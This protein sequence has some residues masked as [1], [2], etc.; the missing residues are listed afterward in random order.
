MKK[1]GGDNKTLP[2]KEMNNFRMITQMIELKKYKKAL[3]TCEQILKKYPKNGETLSVKGYLLNLIDENNKDEAFK[4]AKEGIKNNLS[5]SFCW[6]LYGCLYKNYKNYEEALK[7]YMKSIQLNRNDH[8]AIKEASIILLHLKKYEQFKDLRI[9]TY[10]ESAKGP[11]DKA[12]IIFS[13]HLLKQYE[14]CH[15]LIKQ[16]EEDL[17]KIDV[18]NGNL[19]KMNNS[20]IITENE[21]HQLL[22]YMSEI[23]LEGKMY[24]E[25]IQFLNK[26]KQLEN[27]KLWYNQMLGLIYLYENDMSQANKYFKEAF[28]V[29][30]ENLNILLL[31]LFTEKEIYID[32]EKSTDNNKSGNVSLSNL[33]YLDYKDEHKM[34]E[35]VKINKN[36]KVLLHESIL[37]IYGS[38]RN[39]KLLSYINKNILNDY[40][41]HNLGMKKYDIYTVSELKNNTNIN[42]INPENFKKGID[43]NS[44]DK[45]IELLTEDIEKECQNINN[46]ATENYNIIQ[47]SNK[48]GFDLF[49]YPKKKVEKSMDILYFYKIKNLNDK[50]EKCFETYFT[51]LQNKYENSNLLK[52]FPLYFYNEI[53]FS[54]YIEKLFRN[55][56]FQKCFTIF[57][58]LKPILTYKNVKILLFLLHK[59]IKNYDKTNKL[60]EFDSDYI[61]RD[62]NS[63]SYVI[64]NF[65]KNDF[66]KREDSINNETLNIHSDK[67]N[68]NNFQ[69]CLDK[70][71]TSEEGSCCNGISEINN[72]K[73]DEVES[74]ANSVFNE[75]NKMKD[76]IGSSS[77]LGM[78]VE[79]MKNENIDNKNK[80]DKGTTTQL[81]DKKL[82]EEIKPKLNKKTLTKEER[83]EHFMLCIYS[84]I[85][86][87]Y[88]YINS[89]KDSLY[90]IDKC[91][92]SIKYK[93]NEEFKYELIF[94][95]GLIYK[96][97]GN[98]LMAYKY[99]D[100]CR[101]HNIGDRFINSKTVKTGL[102]CGLI[103][104]SR[105]IAT[106]FTNPLDNNF[107]KNITDTQCFWIEYALALSYFNRHMNIHLNKSIS[108]EGENIYQFKTDSSNDVSN[109]ISGLNL[110]Q[111]ISDENGSE[112]IT[113]NLKVIADNDLLARNEYNDYN[114]SLF[115]L[116]LGHKQFIDIHEDYLCF[117]YYVLRKV[118]YRSYRH[119]LYMSSHI[120]SSRFYRRFGKLLI[121]ICLH[122]ND[123]GIK[124]KID[125]SKNN[126]K[127]NKPTTIPHPTEDK[128][129]YEHM[130]KEPLENAMIYMNTF[131]SQPNA[132]IS[133]YAL[134]YEIERRRGNDYIKLINIIHEIKKLFP[135]HNYYY[136]LG[137]LI[138][139][140]LYAV[141]KDKVDDEK[142]KEITNKLNNILGLNYDTYNEEILRKE[143]ANYINNFMKFFNE[144]KKGDLRYLQ[145][146]FEIY[147]HCNEK[148]SNDIL[149]NEYMD[150]RKNKLGRCFKFFTFLINHKKTHSELSEATNR[151]KEMCKETYPLATAFQ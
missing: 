81:K 123:I 44:I 71:K 124:P 139:H 151:F 138:S 31:I 100:I 40:V 47:W 8:K 93:I 140:Y 149:L 103:K 62:K 24:K 51:N 146:A 1:D 129:I 108:K 87:L 115:F 64:N 122:M 58:Y 150:P 56:C 49:Y 3:K 45:F 52:I 111:V 92:N 54:Y 86:Q 91:I 35:E 147:T 131:L 37:Y 68:N 130:K 63:N 99:L 80:I 101:N 125:Q 60:C 132:D 41:C 12:L 117:Y 113:L 83:D 119:L 134:N 13:Y 50:E 73:Y 145:S 106:I 29:N 114:K 7:C 26:H 112:Q 28:S 57:N 97:N 89:A 88:D 126:K 20:N 116:H 27:D 10:K 65:E 46:I 105:K 55:L 61:L 82:K 136:K 148:I 142:M 94:I 102:K 39:L 23:L 137:P 107:L 5:S 21:K 34:N 69:N 77:S 25:C 128:E 42:P 75:K 30:S 36:T 141:S 66:E 85:S 4:Y 109:D 96:R 143:R 67:N 70:N 110:G 90:F 17:S 72:N 127:K 118:L 38:N 15:Y 33:F 98:Y 104:Y 59:Y 133:V 11:K 135:H 84:F 18:G 2:N 48:I 32:G 76:V 53:K 79:G 120:F 43:E 121:R 6:Y 14:K 95:K 78:Y 22:V 9:D 16:V 144:K 74:E 19:D